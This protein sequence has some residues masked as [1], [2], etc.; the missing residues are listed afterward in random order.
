M[1]CV[2]WKLNVTSLQA[3]L[4]SCNEMKLTVDSHYYVLDFLCLLRIDHEDDEK[5]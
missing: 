1:I 3:W 4:L 2:R 5:R